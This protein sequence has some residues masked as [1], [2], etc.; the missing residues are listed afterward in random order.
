MHNFVIGVCKEI[1]N[2]QDCIIITKGQGHSPRGI[3]GRDPT[4]GWTGGMDGPSTLQ[5]QDERYRG[6]S[7]EARGWKLR[8]VIFSGS[9]NKVIL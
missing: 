4:V 2:I 5:D 6:A 1:M 7:L 9:Q 3:R 8:G